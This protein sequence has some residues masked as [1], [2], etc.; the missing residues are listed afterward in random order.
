MGWCLLTLPGDRLVPYPQTAQKEKIIVPAGTLQAGPDQGEPVNS[1]LVGVGISDRAAP[2]D[3]P[4]ADAVTAEALGYDFGSAFD[5]PVVDAA[6][7][8]AVGYDRLPAAGRP[9]RTYPGFAAGRRSA[10]TGSSRR[11]GGR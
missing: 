1:L 10:G 11:P 3:D 2:G 9:A 5:H 6:T 4:A 7:A 8:L